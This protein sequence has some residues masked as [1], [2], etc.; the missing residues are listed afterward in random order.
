MLQ[1]RGQPTGRYGSHVPHD[2]GSSGIGDQ[3]DRAINNRFTSLVRFGPSK[4]PTISDGVLGHAPATVICQICNSLGHSTTQ[5]I[6]LYRYSNSHKFPKSL[7]AMSLGNVP[8]SDTYMDS[9]LSLNMVNI[10]VI[11]TN[12]LK[13]IGSDQSH[14]W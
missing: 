3:H 12:P 10:E 5:C 8:P 14:S 4:S 6:E 11:I 13:Y 9:D 7:A 2:S 1:S